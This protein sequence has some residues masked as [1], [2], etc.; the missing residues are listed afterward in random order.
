M[1]EH[2]HSIGLNPDFS[3]HDREDSADL[4]NLC[5]HGLGL[6]KTDTRFPAKGTCLAIY[7]RAVNAEAPLAE[8]LPK[9]FPWCAS[10]EP[11]LNQLFGAY[12]QAKQAQNVFEYDDL[13]LAWG[14]HRRQAGSWAL[15]E[16]SRGEFAPSL[17]KT[18]A[19]E[20]YK[21]LQ[22]FTPR[23][24]TISTRNAAF[25]ADR[26]SKPTVPPHRPNGA[27]SAQPDPGRV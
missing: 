21:G 4:M 12:V 10:W 2:A 19:G 16:Q 9:Q 24:S 20:R 13:L 27:T 6:S 22:L 8:V 7:S 15:G 11:Q 1:R 14:R 23:S 26:T 18:G 25:P 17:S 3:I 5:R